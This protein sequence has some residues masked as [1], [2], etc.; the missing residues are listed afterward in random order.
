MSDFTT[1]GVGYS[2][3]P[4]T[5]ISAASI[6]GWCANIYMALAAVGNELPGFINRTT[7]AELSPR[8]LDGLV[9]AGLLLSP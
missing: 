6:E 7:V 5:Q 8:S 4:Q 3:V 1:G 2:F 9:R